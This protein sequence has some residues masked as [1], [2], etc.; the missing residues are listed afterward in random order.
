MGDS[1]KEEY[2]TQ[3]NFFLPL[4]FP[5]SELFAFFWKHTIET[6]RKRMTHKESR[7]VQGEVKD[8]ISIFPLFV[9]KN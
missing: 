5:V 1:Y 8:F 9:K 3:G 2:I 4:P 6:I 7:G